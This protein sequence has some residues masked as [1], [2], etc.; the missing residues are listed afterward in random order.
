M[1]RLIWQG[2]RWPAV[3]VV[4]GVLLV[5]QLGTTGALVKLPRCRS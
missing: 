5:A 1:H 4:A 2:E 3:G